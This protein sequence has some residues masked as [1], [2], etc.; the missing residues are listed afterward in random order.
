MSPVSRARKK[1]TEPE[2]QS[3]NGL[4]KDVLRDFSAL[5][6]ES[7]AFDVELLASEVIGSWWHIETEEPLGQELIAFA[8]R[9]ITP[10]AAALLAALKVVAVTEEERK[11]AGVAFDVVLGR[12]IPEPVWA[13]D[14]GAVTPGECWRTSDV[15]G[16][17]TS[18]LCMFSHG[19]HKH[20]LLALL[21][22]AE[23]G[24]VR[25]LAVVEQPHEI[26][27]EMRER[28]EE[29]PDLVTASQV[30]AAEAHRLLADGIAL[31]DGLEDADVSE[32]YA[33]FHA[34]ALARC[35]A[36]PEPAPAPAL[37][38]WPAEARESAVEEF[39]AASDLEDAE[40]G[41][42]IARLL[43]DHGVETDPATPLR[44]GPEK[45]ATFLERLMAGE[46]ELGLDQEEAVAPVVL[47]W[48]EWAA[49][50]AG[51][52]EAAV[53]ELLETVE[54]FLEEYAGDESALDAYLDGAEAE[55]ATELADLLERRMFAVPS[56]LT[57][58]G[59]EEIELDPSDPEQRRLSVI[60][61]HPELHE[62]LAEETLDDEAQTLLVLK[63]ALVD[64]LWE[65][66]P[67][68]LW[69]AVRRLQEDD[70]DRDEILDRLA[71]VLGGQ[72]RES[73][74]ETLDYD[75]DAYREE[76]EALS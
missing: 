72:L 26:L 71:G 40:S 62:A 56:L 42:A 74:S 19:D 14:V 59:D 57:E 15:Y 63:T 27:A 43:V 1:A 50:R 35:R 21:D 67:A 3:V 2:A 20:G 73:D 39:V 28:A 54:G 45:I 76:L 13:G 22:F 52:P 65:N 44:V 49:G 30:D 32:D 9:K 36:L 70:L 60:G 33:R 38:E 34:I 4:F 24:R 69:V 16:D 61:E 8:Q 41:R 12:G 51:L 46:V 58:I 66:E 37:P 47:A 11:A 64:Q 18:L 48:T 17:E 7:G 53:D 75:E 55:D 6:A 25:D 68:E 10:G 31:T 5:D 23:R 29:S